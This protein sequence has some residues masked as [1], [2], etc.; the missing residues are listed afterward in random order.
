[1]ANEQSNTIAEDRGFSTPCWIWQG[2]LKD[3][4][5]I[6][7]SPRVRVH[8]AIY[9]R[10]HGPI[11]EGYEPDHL[12]GVKCCVNPAHLEAV[13]HAE[14]VRRGPH[15]KLTMKVAQEIRRLAE[16]GEY[17]QS[18]L[19]RMFGALDQTVYLILKNRQWHD[20]DWQPG[21][22]RL[23]AASHG[24]RHPGSKVTEADVKSIRE[25]YAAGGISLSQ[26]ARKFG[27][28]VATVHHIVK[29]RTWTH[30]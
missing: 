5:A 16:M 30:L 9:E 27:I 6:T 24:E 10:E 25:Q 8:R 12:C 7:G 21:Q 18:E 19:A 17:S 26:L 13:T 14:N 2:T 15:T 20:V 28:G 4:Y 23:R 29:R 1:M 3:G 11:P 22:A